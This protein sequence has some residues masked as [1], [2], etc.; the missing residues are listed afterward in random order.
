M[1][2]DGGRQVRA[3]L[4]G[5]PTLTMGRVKPVEDLR[6]SSLSADAIHLAWTPTDDDVEGYHVYRASGIHDV[7][8]RLNTAEIRATVYIDP[9]PLVGNNVYMVRALRL[10]TT[11]SGTYYS[12]SPGVI[13]SISFEVIRPDTGYLVSCFP[14]PFEFGTT[15]RYHLPAAEEVELHIF[16]VDGRLVKTL[17]DKRQEAG[18][19]NEVW[20]GTD[21]SGNSV[22]SGVYFYKLESSDFVMTEKLILAR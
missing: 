6:M 20:D 4:M 21:D 16:A 18:W 8:E 14:N 22:A 11:A 2:S 15:I 1:A 12:L 17:V 5:D 13:D 10:E 9:N 19:H 3:A 7:F